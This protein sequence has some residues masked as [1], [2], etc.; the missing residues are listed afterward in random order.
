MIVTA[1]E[2]LR[3]MASVV[4]YAAGCP[5]TT[6]GKL[7]TD[8]V[9]RAVTGTDVNFVMVGTGELS[10]LLSPQEVMDRE[11]VVVF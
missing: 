8:S 1:L 3:P 6:C 2:G 5:L 10:C 11:I 9:R 4:Q 7:D